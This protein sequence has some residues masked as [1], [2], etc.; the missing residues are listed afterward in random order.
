[1]TL[2][3]GS[4]WQLTVRWGL[5]MLLDCIVLAHR[6]G[7]LTSFQGI[8]ML[9]LY[10]LGSK[11]TRRSDKMQM[12]S[13]GHSEGSKSQG[14]A[15]TRGCRPVCLPQRPWGAPLFSYCYRDKGLIHATAHAMPELKWCSWP[16]DE[17]FFLSPPASLQLSLLW[18]PSS[19][20]SDSLSR[21]DLCRHVRKLPK[22]DLSINERRKELHGH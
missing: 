5:K 3:D 1:M 6:I 15:V 22:K 9:I 7:K 2:L 10:S 12:T 20:A 14:S 8:R 19:N 4:G 18:L 13:H 16:G 21:R 17:V 11:F